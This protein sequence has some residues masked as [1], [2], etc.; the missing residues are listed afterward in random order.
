MIVEMRNGNQTTGRENEM[1]SRKMKHDGTSDNE[2]YKRFV[3][4]TTRELEEKGDK[5]PA[6]NAETIC[7]MYSHHF[8]N[9][10]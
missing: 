9:Y 7:S 8:R 4:K 10:K 5:N 3:E 6:Q 1:K 2:E